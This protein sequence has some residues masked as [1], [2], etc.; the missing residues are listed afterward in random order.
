MKKA[1]TLMTALAFLAGPASWNQ[2]ARAVADVEYG[3]LVAF[4][5]ILAAAVAKSDLP[6]SQKYKLINTINRWK[7]LPPTKKNVAY[8]R[9]N[10]ARIRRLLATANEPNSRVALKRYMADKKSPRRKNKTT[11]SMKYNLHQTFITRRSGESGYNRA[12]TQSLIH[13][14]DS[15]FSRGTS[16]TSHGIFIHDRTPYLASPG[17]T[18]R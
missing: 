11:E 6:P 4:I 10:V 12:P 2:P 16:Q 7:E 1:I 9:R 8:I 14:A 18:G 17:Q 3:M 13:P 15:V 5:A